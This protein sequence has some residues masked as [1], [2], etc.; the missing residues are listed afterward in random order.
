MVRPNILTWFS[1]KIEN[2]IYP[3]TEVK[4]V[5][6]PTPTNK[7]DISTD[8]HQH[9]GNIKNKEKNCDADASP[10]DKRPEGDSPKIKNI[11]VEIE[12]K[13]NEMEIACI[14]ETVEELEIANK[15]KVDEYEHSL[16]KWPSGRSWLTKVKI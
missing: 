11:S 12:S 8:H 6:S 13:P 7:S 4:E 1:N 9:N 3:F 14:D 5:I 10:C 2:K 15:E 16:W